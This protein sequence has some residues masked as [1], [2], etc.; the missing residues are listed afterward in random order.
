MLF[1]RFRSLKKYDPE[2]EQAL[3]NEIEADGGLEKNDLKA[4]ILAALLTIMPF[5]LFLFLLI[6]LA[7][8]LFVS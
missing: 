1:E 8:W 6:A 7:C 5:A 4:M 3:Q 2:K